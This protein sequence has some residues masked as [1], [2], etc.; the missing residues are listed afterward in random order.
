[1]TFELDTLEAPESVAGGAGE[2]PAGVV[3]DTK[4]LPPQRARLA[5]HLAWHRATADELATLRDNRERLIAQI[6][7]VSAA[8]DELAATV[9]ADA[10]GL[11][12]CMRKGLGW[13]LAQIKGTA[14]IGLEARIAASLHQSEVAQRSLPML[15]AEIA[16]LEAL[17]AV[18]ESRQ[19][20]FVADALIEE[21][22]ELG[23]DIADAI[24]TIRDASHKLLA[25]HAA[26]NIEPPEDLIFQAPKFAV[27]ALAFADLRVHVRQDP[28][29]AGVWK[30]LAKVW[31]EDP[32]ADASKI[33][34][35][36]DYDAESVDAKV[37][38]QEYLN[39]VRFEHRNHKPTTA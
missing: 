16:R 30:E 7:K 29:A 28:A 21:A 10:Q 32:R 37:K 33:L 13:S 19:Q 3:A 12:D 1:M 35:F 39:S 24:E 5:R 22:N 9:D 25:L 38:Y 15:D 6:A 11:F 20:E 27:P 14:R 18:I 17:L 26:L 8:Q 23:L 2:P 34:K 31:A 36:R 4:G